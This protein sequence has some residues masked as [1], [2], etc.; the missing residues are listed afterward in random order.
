MK[1]T[2]LYIAMAALCLFFTAHAQSPNIIVR[3]L[4][5]GDTISQAVWH[6]QLQAVNHPQGKRQITINNYRGKLLILDFWATWCSSCLKH[7][8]LADSLQNEFKDLI[9]ILLVNAQNTRDTKEKILTTLQ[10]F[11]KPG[12]PTF[13]LPCAINDTLLEKLFPHFSLPH[14]VWIDQNGIV[15][16]ITSADELTRDHIIRFLNGGKAPVYQKSDFDARRPLYTIK[17]LPTDHLQQF[18][19][20]LKGKIDGISG[21]GMR[22]INDTTR[23]IILHNRSLLSMYR[24]VLS[25]KVGGLSENRILVEVKDPSKLS[26]GS[27]NEKKSDWERANFYSYELIV[28]LSRMNH[29]YDDVLADLNRYTPYKAGFEKRK[30]LCWILERIG[31]ADLIHTKGGQYNDALGDKDSSR[32]NNA[33]LLNLCI[34]LNKISSNAVILDHTGYTQNIDLKFKEAITDM[35]TMKRYLKAYGLKLYS[36]YQKVEMLIVKDKEVAGN[37]NSNYYQTHL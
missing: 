14:Y 2:I 18:S 24:S 16:S 4:N 34:Y 37:T 35:N 12:K 30:I 9:Q 8:P 25:A 13:S 22:L 11:N 19:M 33:P 23:G 15:R 26:Y 20:L 17:E 10:R 1:K 7:F 36:T 5:I 31:N 3:S 29:L 21:G 32:L 6:M 28:P 27:S